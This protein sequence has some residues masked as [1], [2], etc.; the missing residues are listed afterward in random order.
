M[1]LRERIEDNPVVWL[2]GSL[3]AGF[4]AGIGAYQAILEIAHLKVVPE[5]RLAEMQSIV[6]ARLPL[7]PQRRDQQD[8]KSDSGT[9]ERVKAG[10]PSKYSVK[11]SNCADG[12]K[13]FVNKSLVE[14]VGF[15]DKSKSIDITNKLR[16]GPNSI[17][18]Q[19][20]NKGGAITYTFEILRNDVAIF[21]ASCGSHNKE[22]CQ[23][24]RGFPVPGGLTVSCTLELS[25]VP[26]NSVTERDTSLTCG[27][28]NPSTGDIG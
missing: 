27:Y 1:T 17:E 9:H 14:Q 11:L 3:L 15:G 23:V 20:L 10:T 25:A 8:G 2:L 24:N 6:P 28:P 7:A 4:L 16:K 26:P 18:F 19:V 22:D 12:S 21:R 5:A 13:V